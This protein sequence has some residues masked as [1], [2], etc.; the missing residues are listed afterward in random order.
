MSWTSRKAGPVAAVILC[1]YVMS[2]S[3]SAQTL[4]QP[5][6]APAAKPAAPPRPAAKLIYLSPDFL[7]HPG[8][9]LS[10]PP[11]PGSP[12]GQRDLA[13]AKVVQ[14]AAGPDRIALAVADDKNETV[15]F[16]GDVL[17]GFEA[18]KLPLTAKLF[19]DARND[20]NFEANRFKDFFARQRPFDVD[21]TVKTCVPSVY[22]AAPRS[23]PSGHATLG[24]SL[25][26]ILAHLIPE[27][28]EAILARAKVYGESRVVCGVHFPS[29]IT[30]S[31]TLG[32]AA[33][34]EMMHNATFKKAFDAAKA[35]LVT[36][37]L[38]K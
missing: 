28:A 4:M 13:A 15:W 30:A 8:A 14:A 7:A 19:A 20:E 35:E 23:Y 5:T 6:A 32:T 9:V 27:K 25:G 34:L 11:N 31:E 18:S 22:D 37:G 16:Y 24:Y 29:D 38:T 17:P 36:A 10:M 2:G 3:A 21:H 33:A 1:A 12:E 26:V